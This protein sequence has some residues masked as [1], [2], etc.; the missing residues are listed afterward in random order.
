[1]IFTNWAV[2]WALRNGQ[3]RNQRSWRHGKAWDV[4]ARLSESTTWGFGNSPRLWHS[5]NTIYI[6]IP[7]IYWLQYAAWGNHITTLIEDLATLSRSPTLHISDLWHLGLQGCDHVLV[8]LLAGGFI[9][10]Q[11]LWIDS[12]HASLQLR[13]LR[14]VVQSSVPQ[15]Q[16]GT[17][18]HIT[19]GSWKMNINMN[20]SLQRYGD[21]V[22]VRS[23]KRPASKIK[24][25]MM[26][27][28]FCNFARQI[29]ICFV[30]F[31]SICLASQWLQTWLERIL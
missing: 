29:C 5:P 28:S 11:Q 30:S 13:V 3:R 8:S 14:L 20:I 26:L 27:T 12:S 10:D 15:L 17:S 19:Y 22:S 2:L 1:M 16:N 31:S 18:T 4:P 23:Q 9:Y 6:N 21:S 24:C 25:W 7:S